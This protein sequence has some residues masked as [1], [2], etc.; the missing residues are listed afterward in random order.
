MASKTIYCAQG[1]RRVAGRLEAFE[2]HQFSTAERAMEGGAILARWA[3][4]VAVFSL[5]GQPDV[6]HWADPELLWTFGDT[7]SADVFDQSSSWVEAA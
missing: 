7:P 5:T 1:F 2:L 3:P 4:G 6:D